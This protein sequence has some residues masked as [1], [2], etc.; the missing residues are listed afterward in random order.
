MNFGGD[1]I[2]S[3]AE[4]LQWLFMLEVF[5]AQPRCHLLQ[6]AFPSLWDS[7]VPRPVLGRGHLRLL[8][9]SVSPLPSGLGET[10]GH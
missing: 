6:E 5:A 2:Q 8:Y 10:L 7:R 4:L 1:T 3:I 9:W